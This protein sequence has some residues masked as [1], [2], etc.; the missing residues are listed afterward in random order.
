MTE[1]N[2]RF[3]TLLI[4]AVVIIAVVSAG[5]IWNYFPKIRQLMQPE[6]MQAF[7]QRLQSFGIWGALVLFI[8]QIL[9]VIS[10]IIPALPIQICA[11]MTYGALGGLLICLAGV[12][13]GSSL[14]FAA[15]K[16]FGQ[17]LIDRFFSSKKQHK[18]HFLYHNTH[19][20][21]I[22]FIL[23][24][25][26]AMP[27]DVLTYIAALTP[28]TLRKF[29]FL[30]MTARIPTILCSTFASN[31]IMQRNYRSAILLFC[32][33]GTIGLICLLLSK[34]ILNWLKKYRKT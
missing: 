3:L 13:A 9:Q 14:V 19:L 26:P 15:V 1:K 7:Q 16:R 28:L 21:E 8:I 22:V 6:N 5:L 4:G 10:G 31:A 11:G 33:S 17:P 25:I 32:I 18:L 23:Y 30:S 2:K 34:K 12:L 20:N 24:L 27:K 29:L